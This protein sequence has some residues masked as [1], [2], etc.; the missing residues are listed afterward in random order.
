[1]EQIDIIY[2]SALQTTSCNTFMNH[3]VNLLV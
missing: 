1:M 3:K 2:G